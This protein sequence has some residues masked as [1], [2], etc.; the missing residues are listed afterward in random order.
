MNDATFTR[1][2]FMT[3]DRFVGWAQRKCNVAPSVSSS[4]F[5]AMELNP[6]IEKQTNRAG[7]KEVLIAVE[8]YQTNYQSRVLDFSEDAD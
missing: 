4:Q 2:V 5:D 6:A 7:E 1:S 8:E 3:K